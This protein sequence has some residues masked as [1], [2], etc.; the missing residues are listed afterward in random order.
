MLQIFTSALSSSAADALYCVLHLTYCI[1]Q[2]QNICLIFKDTFI[3][4][5]K[6]LILIIYCFLDFTELFLCI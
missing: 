4:S 5:V 6:F 2:L 3:F 1:F